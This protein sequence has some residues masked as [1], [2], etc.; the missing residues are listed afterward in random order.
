MKENALKEKLPNIDDF[1]KKKRGG[2]GLPGG[3]SRFIIN[4]FSRGGRVL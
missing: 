1:I 3:K 4:F 2:G